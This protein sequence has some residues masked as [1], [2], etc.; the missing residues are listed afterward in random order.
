MSTPHQTTSA[1]TFAATN[2][3]LALR[4]AL[5]AFIGIASPMLATNA[6]AGN[7]S[8]NAAACREVGFGGC[9]AGSCSCGGS[10]CTC[11]CC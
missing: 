10:G 2:N 6:Y 5:L 9:C 11:I 3:E 8:C 1:P 4:L 7:C